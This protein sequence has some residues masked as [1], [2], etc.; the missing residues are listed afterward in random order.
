MEHR[1]SQVTRML[2][3]EVA[4]SLSVSHPPVYQTVADRLR[5]S[6][7]LGTY[8]PGVVLPSER[9]LA[10]M[11]G[12]S[13]VTVREAVRVLQAEGYLATRRGAGGGMILLANTEAKE[14]LLA[15]LRQRRDDFEAL[16][17][18][19]EATKC[20]A[21]RLAATRRDDQDLARAEA[22]I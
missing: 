8:L 4:D 17:E 22:A 9:A 5:H 7:H 20:A 13:R 12:V 11:M 2:P 14:V 3:S 15:R 19:R 18:F 10:A 6:I 21:A 1:D 16:V